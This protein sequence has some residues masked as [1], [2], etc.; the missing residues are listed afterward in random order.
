MRDSTCLPVTPPVIQADFPASRAAIVCD[1]VWFPSAWLPAIGR[2]AKRRRRDCRYGSKVVYT[3]LCNVECYYARP[4]EVL[5]VAE[6]G[7]LNRCSRF[8]HLSED[9]TPDVMVICRVC[10]EPMCLEPSGPNADSTSFKLTAATF[11]LPLCRL[12]SQTSSM[13]LM[14]W[15]RSRSRMQCLMARVEVSHC[16]V[17]DLDSSERR[18]A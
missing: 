2:L 10:L 5:S 14:I 1:I 18:M 11:R 6:T 12:S 16:T 7:V 17:M 8:M 13:V 9:Q 3:K 4:Y 15:G